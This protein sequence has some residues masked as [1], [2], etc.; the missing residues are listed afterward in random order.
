MTNLAVKRLKLTNFRNYEAL[1]IS[2]ESAPII[3]TGENG[4]GKTNILEAISLLTAGRGIRSAKLS[5]ID[6]VGAASGDLESR[7]F[8]N[9]PWTVYSEIESRDGE[10][11]IGTGR[12][13]SS[14]KDKRII[15]ID[16]ENIRSQAELGAYFSVV[17]LTP[18]MDSLLALGASSRREYLDKIVASFFPDHVKHLSVYSHA[19][20]ERQK[21]LAMYRYDES[22]VAITER[23]MAE[24]A[25]AVAHA[26]IETIEYL[27][28]AI[29]Y[30]LDSGSFEFPKA[31]ISSIGEVEEMLSFMKAVEVES[32]M[33]EI[34][35]D[36][37]GVDKDSGRASRGVHKS[38]FRI[39]HSEKNMP[40]ELCST[41]EQKAMLLSITLAAARARKM[42]FGAAPVVLLDEVVS[43]L[44]EGKR[45]QLAEEIKALSL[46]C[47]LTGTEKEFFRDF[48]GDLQ[49]LTVENSKILV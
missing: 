6:R 8:S 21:L 46:Q 40:A 10:L 32:K 36:A 38:D 35:K 1:D 20:S 37:R 5:T 7:V 11:S 28:K 48:K 18:R 42:W 13:P 2:V 17:Y 16:G 24:N 3:I 44:D 25:V 19:K 33:Q 22:W 27:R 39:V 47:W 34:F 9:F 29:N 23:R 12:D 31:I 14:E 43:H 41:G 49:L 15:K 4:S 26:R 45:A 30:Q